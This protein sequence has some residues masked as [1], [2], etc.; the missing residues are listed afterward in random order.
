MRYICRKCI[1]EPYTLKYTQEQSGFVSKV[2]KHVIDF[3]SSN[4]LLIESALNDPLWDKESISTYVKSSFL[5]IQDGCDYFCTFCTIPLARGKSR[6]ASIEETIKEAN[7]I[8]QTEITQ[9]EAARKLGISP[10]NLNS[11]ILKN[12]IDWPVKKQGRRAKCMDQK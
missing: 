2:N 3:P 12:D 10:Q 6:N 7:K 4:K 11:F 5:K 1:I 9:T 8:A